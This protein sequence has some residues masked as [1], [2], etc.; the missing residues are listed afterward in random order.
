MSMLDLSK[1]IQAIQHMDPVR[2]NGKVTQVVGLTIE[3]QGPEAK[4]GEV[5]LIYSQQNEEPIM[6]E[7]VGFRDNKVLLMP[8]GE[9]SAIGPG[10]D[11]VA[12]GKPL[13]VKVGTEILGMVLDGL[14][15]PMIGKPLPLGN[16]Q[17]TAESIAATADS[18]AIKRGC[19]CDRWT[20]YSWKRTACRYFRRFR[21]REKYITW[22]DCTEYDSRCQR[23]CAHW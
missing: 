1:Y 5:C 19:A 8:L 6:A 4:L 14:G 7:V 17:S 9:V 20:H 13:M 22:N 12:T 3:S 21:C 10:C 11:V 15:R 2:I 16:E 18:G 23:D